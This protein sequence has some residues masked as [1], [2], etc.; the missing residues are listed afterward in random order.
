MFSKLRTPFV[1]LSTR[2]APYYIYLYIMDSRLFK[3]EREEE[4][5]VFTHSCLELA[6]TIDTLVFIMEDKYVKNSVGRLVRTKRY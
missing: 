2:S 6:T 1:L 3:R 4:L 5:F